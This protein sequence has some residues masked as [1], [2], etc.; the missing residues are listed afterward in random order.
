MQQAQANR[1]S[2]RLGLV[3]VHQ[4]GAGHD[5]DLVVLGLADFR[6]HFGA[7]GIV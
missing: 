2:D 7:V 5:D 6:A 4:V 3:I 1:R